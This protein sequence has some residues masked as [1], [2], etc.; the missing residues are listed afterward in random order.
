M[1]LFNR[2]KKEEAVKEETEKGPWESAY[3]AQP[4]AFQNEEGKTF[5]AFTLTESTDT[6]LPADPENMYG[7]GGRKVS[8]FRLGFCSLSEDRILD[9]L[10]YYACIRVLAPYVEEIREPFVRIRQLSNDELKEIIRLVHDDLENRDAL[11]EAFRKNMEFLSQR[12]LSAETVKKTFSSE[13]AQLYVFEDVSFATGNVTVADPLAVLPDREHTAFLDETLTP[14]KYPLVLAIAEPPHDGKRIAGMKLQVSDHEAVTYETAGT[15]YMK[16]GIRYEDLPGFAVEAGLACI[17]DEKAA[18]AYW[19]FLDEWTEEH[20]GE[21]IYNH[22]FAELFAQSYEEHP[23]VQR[24]GGD[25]IR[26]NIPN[27]EEEMILFASGYGDGYYNTY[28]GY[29]SDGKLAEIVSIFIDPELYM[30][31]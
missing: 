16:N 14:G 15:W 26:W 23:E 27:S 22:Y 1:G 7:I 29:D 3:Q 20:A 6:I 24:E 13:N 10:P 17:T 11:Q 9:T 8:N 5:I 2:K 30:Q 28:C 4:Q 12:E 21:N 19:Q 31:K 25:F 18:E